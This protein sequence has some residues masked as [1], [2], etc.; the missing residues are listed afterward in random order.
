M[1]NN[2][3]QPYRVRML[4]EIDDYYYKIPAGTIGT[5][6]KRDDHLRIRFPGIDGLVAMSHECVERIDD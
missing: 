1:K 5:V 6:E 4:V 3:F 2:D